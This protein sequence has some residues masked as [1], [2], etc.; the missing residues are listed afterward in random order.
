MDAIY[1][2][3]VSLLLL[4]A[5]I[6]QLVALQATSYAYGR[7]YVD[8]D[9]TRLACFLLAIVAT[10][11]GAVYHYR[12]CRYEESACRLEKTER[13]TAIG[14]RLQRVDSKTVITIGLLKQKKGD[15]ADLSEARKVASGLAR[16]H[17]YRIRKNTVPPRAQRADPQECR[18]GKGRTGKSQ[19]Q[20]SHLR[21]HPRHHLSHWQDRLTRQ[22]RGPP[23][24]TH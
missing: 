24:E 8:G 20:N 14:A 19:E 17:L 1:N 9:R 23:L 4:L 7:A 12:A 11:V 6:R 22:C 3:C 5:Q 15:R 16:K 21:S 10:V 2:G 18:P 13:L